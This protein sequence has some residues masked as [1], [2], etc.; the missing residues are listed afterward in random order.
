MC[1]KYEGRKSKEDMT[2]STDDKI[3]SLNSMLVSLLKRL[4]LSEDHYN[5]YCNNGKDIWDWNNRESFLILPRM[6][7]VSPCY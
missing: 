1:I 7:I 5:Q 4:N 6:Y 3:E 2:Y